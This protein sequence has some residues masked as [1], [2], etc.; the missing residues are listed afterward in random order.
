MNAS[1]TPPRS[2]SSELGPLSSEACGAAR[3]EGDGEPVG[4]SVLDIAA[5]LAWLSSEHGRVLRQ[6][7]PSLVDDALSGT[8]VFNVDGFGADLGAGTIGMDNVFEGGEFSAFRGWR[9]FDDLSNFNWLQG[10]V[11]SGADGWIEMAIPYS[12][13]FANGAV[14]A[15]GTVVGSVAAI[16]NNYGNSFS[17]QS[18]P[19]T[20]EES[21][22]TFEAAMTFELLEVE[23]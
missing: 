6:S 20:S 23:R 3:S 18:V 12:L 17:N 4:D 19:E 7:A 22:S 2:T 15:G 9:L 5:L 16:G 10:T 13:L 11:V 8:L 21:V 14:P 1:V